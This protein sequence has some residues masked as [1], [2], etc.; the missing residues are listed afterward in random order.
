MHIPVQHIWLAV[1]LPALLYFI[2]TSINTP[3]YLQFKNSNGRGLLASLQLVP[4]FTPEASH[5]HLQGNTILSDIEDIFF[6]KKQKRANSNEV[7]NED[8][9]VH[10]LAYPLETILQSG[11]PQFQNHHQYHMAATTWAHNE[12]LGRGY[13]LISDQRNSGN[14]WQ[15]EVGGGPITIGRS[16]Y[17]KESGCRSNLWSPCPN[18]TTSTDSSESVCLKESLMGSAGLT[19]QSAKDS[20]NFHE[21]KLIVA[22]RGEKR[23]IRMETDGARTPLVLDVPSLCRLQNGASKWNRINEPGIVAYS[24]FGDLFFTDHVTRGETGCNSTIATAGLYRLKEVVSVPPIPFH[25]SRQAHGWMEEDRE[26]HVNLSVK[27]SLSSNV[28]L[29]FQSMDVERIS[30][31]AIC[32][33]FT[34]FYIGVRTVEENGIRKF[35]ILKIIE[36]DDE[37]HDAVDLKDEEDSHALGILDKKWKVFS[38]MTNLYSGLNSESAGDIGIALTLDAAGNVYATYPSGIAIIDPLGEL[39][40]TIP[41]PNQQSPPNSLSFG[42]D[43]YL[44]MTLKDKLMRLR[45]KSKPITFPTNMVVP[46]KN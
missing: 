20:G 31:I 8:P 26:E 37:A 16:L 29:L 1:F 42:H 34:S 35:L 40:V 18:L 13:L 4:T 12:E 30:G 21:G 28:E 9:S 15:W 43:G 33:D 36:E 38:D 14:I 25:K 7:E 19:I 3:S 32:P 2:Y 44:Y 41:F 39:L 6:L 45:V 22:E 10:V 17:L 27:K 5:I 11:N 24:P 46:S 23:I